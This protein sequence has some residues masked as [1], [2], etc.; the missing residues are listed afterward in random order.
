MKS[1]V[2]KLFST[3]T[4]A[5]YALKIFLRQKLICQTGKVSDTS[6]RPLSEQLCLVIKTTFPL[7]P[8]LSVSEL[9]HGSYPSVIPALLLSGVSYLTASEHSN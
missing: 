3:F 5:Y 7:P 2:H 9:L 8:P 4:L 6:S 1:H